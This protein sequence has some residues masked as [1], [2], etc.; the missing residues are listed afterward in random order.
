MTVHL[1]CGLANGLTVFTGVAWGAMGSE[2]YDHGETFPRGSA[3]RNSS[4]P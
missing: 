4:Y 3:L 1:G 2:G